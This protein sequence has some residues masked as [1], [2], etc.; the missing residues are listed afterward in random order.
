V[1]DAFQEQPAEGNP[2]PGLPRNSK[3][4]L[5]RLLARQRGGVRGGWRLVALGEDVAAE[6]D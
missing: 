1:T 5:R 3:M 4:Q 2:T 6:I